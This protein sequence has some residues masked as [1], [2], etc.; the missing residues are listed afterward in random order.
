MR[1][2][3]TIATIVLVGL[4]LGACSG[5]EYQ[6][7]KQSEP[8]SDSYDAQLSRQ[9]LDL[10]GEQYSEGDYR[11]SDFF[12]RR[13]M[14]ASQGRRFGPEEPRVRRLPPDVK[15][16]A[17]EGYRRLVAAQAAGAIDK[18]PTDTARAQVM[19]D[20]W[21]E[22]QEEDRSIEEEQIAFC[23]D[24][25]WKALGTI[26]AALK[27]PPPPPAPP[28]PP[29]PP[30]VA[31]TYLMFF[32]LNSAALTPE[33]QTIVDDAATNAKT[34]G[35]RSLQVVGHTDR[36]GTAAYNMRL[37]ARRAETVGQALIER[38]IPAEDISLEAMGE[39]D[40]LVPTEDGV[41]EPQNRRVVIQF[42]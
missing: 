16:Q 5:L 3:R 37:S 33:A 15:P 27:P 30:P 4:A 8:K 28:A 38:G 36:T 12:A 19:F 29:A 41:P 6:R 39:E 42:R 34:A 14:A 18:V 26:E 23:R 7:A 20:C 40:P 2:L 10:S 24:A 13:S 32:D 25:F 21:M 1:L 9:Y 22:E 35:V 17:N 31:Q 11:N